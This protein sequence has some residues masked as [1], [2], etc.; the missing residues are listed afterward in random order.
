[1]DPKTYTKGAEAATVSI[2]QV[3]EEDLVFVRSVVDVA[4]NEAPTLK[5]TLVMIRE[6]LTW[7]PALAYLTTFGVEL[8]IDGQ[9]A[10]VLFTLFQKKRAGFTQTTAGYYTSILYVD[11]SIDKPSWGDAHRETVASSTSSLAHSA[12]SLAIL[13]TAITA[14]K[15][16]KPGRSRLVLLWVL[17]YLLE[18]C[19]LRNANL[20]TMLSVRCFNMI[21]ILIWAV[22]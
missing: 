19:T 1:M 10:N 18:A 12:D 22:V 16:R 17:R 14:P 8:S 2:E 15:E 7:L 9:M 11:S 13:S 20:P 21:L 5:A 4:I 3:K 6:P